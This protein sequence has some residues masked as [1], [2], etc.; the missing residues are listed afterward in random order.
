M[1]FALLAALVGLLIGSFLNACIFR[2]P[3][4]ITLWSPARSFCPECEAQIAWFDNIPLFSFLL[5]KGRCR[6]CQL[7]I[8]N[9]YWMV[10][11]LCG[12]MYF[13]IVYRFGVTA[14]AWKLLIF[15]AI[16]VALIFTDF[17]ERILPDEF[18][19]GGA[20]LGIVIAW[21]VHLGFT[22]MVLPY[23]ASPAVISVA[24]S[25]FA[26]AFGY[27]AL[28]FIGW[29]YLRIRGREG[30]GLGDLKMVAMMGAFLGLSPTLFALMA[31]SILGSIVGL[32]YIR[33]NQEEAQTYELPFGSFLGIA[34]LGVAWMEAL[35]IAG[36]AVV[37]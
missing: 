8:P 26:A 23:D 17:E 22:T 28:W 21:F 33:L 6:K 35:R 29:L 4:D 9:R 2:L 20:L 1:L 34:A 25:A 19:K 5:L 37:H 16:N 11:L 32:I 12:V 30:M 27:G 24:E 7:R 31:G 36:D 15:T 14:I 18:T 13:V 10:E 3:R